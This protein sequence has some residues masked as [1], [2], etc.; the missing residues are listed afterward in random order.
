MRNL[1]LG[2]VAVLLLSAGIAHAADGMEADLISVDEQGGRL[3]AVISVI[4]SEGE[5]MLG[6]TPADF[7]ATL[8]GE[9]V[10]VTSAQTASE[11]RES[12]DVVLAVDVSGSMLGAP[13]NL[14]K[15]ATQ[16]FVNGLDPADQAG[17]VAFAEASEVRQTLTSDKAA[18]STAVSGLVAVGNTA[19]YNGVIDAAKLIGESTAGRRLVVLLSDGEDTIA[20][21]KREESIQVA[22]D[23]GVPMIVI[24]LG[25]QL[26]REYLAAVAAATGGQFIEAPTASTLANIYENLANVIRSQYV[27][28]IAM[29]AGMD[30]SVPTHLRI[31]I[32]D[33]SNSTFVE[34]ELAPL[35]GAVPPAFDL[36]VT[37]FT[38]GSELTAATM[39]SVAAPEGVQLA[40]VEYSVDG[41]LVHTSTQAPFN[42]E[43]APTGLIPGNHIVNIVARDASGRAGERQVIFSIPVPPVEKTQLPIMPVLGGVA[44][45]GILF[46]LVK[47]IGKR[48]AV[49][50]G[51]PEKYANRIKP[52]SGRIADAVV[53]IEPPR[54]KDAPLPPPPQ[55]V[56]RPRGRLI[57]MHEASIR[58]GNLGV[59]EYEVRS[60]PLTIGSNPS[61]DVVLHDP[62]GRIAGE[63]ARVWV[64]KGR[65]I[66]HRLTTL[67]AMATEGVTSGWQLLDSGDELK[68]GPYRLTFAPA[69]EPEEEPEPAPAP[70]IGLRELWPRLNEEPGQMRTGSD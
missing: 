42:F 16:Q 62:D 68:V 39:L 44:V 37:G 53:P 70:Q 65:L 30:R 9:P 52:W 23:T 31:D 2:V 57:V 34:R 25:N 4:D 6:L 11:A 40:S 33:G 26:D 66:Y 63:E 49:R 18:L 43:I 54:D 58:A 67:S 35:P 41:T 45:V 20:P 48:R 24:G 38:S 10:L 28:R 5:A 47:K 64:Q 21:D 12:V 1:W 14:A 32:T 50:S 7:Q 8:D 61:C 27:V 15:Q 3:T 56:D 51:S 17:I 36:T 69:V 55:F 59:E 29:P 22:A 19:L 46:L 60:T 13:M